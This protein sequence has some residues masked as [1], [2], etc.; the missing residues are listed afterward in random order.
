[1]AKRKNANGMGSLITL[2]NGY[3]QQIYTVRDNK[4]KFVRIS[5]TGKTAKEARDK[6]DR[7]LEKYNKE[8]M[9][10]KNKITFGDLAAKTIET[11][12]NTGEITENTYRRKMDSML[13]F[14]SIKDIPM[15][16][17]NEDIVEEFLQKE[18]DAGLSAST[19]SK[20]LV[21]LRATFDAAVKRKVILTSD[22]FMLYVKKPKSKKEVEKVRALTLEEQKELIQKLVEQNVPYK[23][24]MMLILYTGL[25]PGEALA[26]NVEDIKLKEKKLY[27][28]KTLSYDQ[29]HKVY[30]ENKTKTKAGT[31][32]VTLTPT[33]IDLLESVMD[34][35]KSGLLFNDNGNLIPTNKVRY[36]LEKTLVYYRIL[37]L[38]IQGKVDLHSLRHTYAT[39]CFE[40]GINAS[41]VQTQLGHRNITTTLDTYTSIFDR[42]ILEGL[43]KLEDLFQ[44]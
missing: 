1:M 30:I 14:E 22:N 5:A 40:A 27:V 31:R 34:G 28:T 18:V 39:R 43:E 29:Y 19:I 32:M 33:A 25:R 2:P 24:V 15:V 37:D 36:Y 38:N 26:L 4:G 21:I 10:D 12:L 23:E 7:K 9:L 35:R 44:S 16:R 42:P 8:K 6:A 3:K 13:R 11:Q 17:L 20:E 41:I